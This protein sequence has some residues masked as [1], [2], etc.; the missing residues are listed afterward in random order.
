MELLRAL[1]GPGHPNGATAADHQ[2][3]DADMG[4]GEAA[5][6]GHPPQ[7]PADPQP[8]PTISPTLPFAPGMTDDAQPAP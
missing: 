6:E 5:S 8:R 3:P 1:G 2:Q 4:D 7:Q